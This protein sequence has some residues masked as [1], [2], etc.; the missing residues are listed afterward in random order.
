MRRSVVLA[1][2]AV[3]GFLAAGCK[4]APCH[5]PCAPKPVWVPERVQMTTCYEVVPARTRPQ[6]AA[7]LGLCRDLTPVQV[8]LPVREKVE[9]EDVATAIVPVYRAACVPKIGYVEVQDYRD[10][11]CPKYQCQAVPQCGRVKVVTVGVGCGPCGPRFIADVCE[12]CRT[13]LRFQPV[14]VGEQLVTVP[15]GT[16][17][18]ETQVDSRCVPI[19]V[20]ARTVTCV[21]G[22]H[23]EDQVVGHRVE[24]T[25]VDRG[26]RVV[27]RGMRV[28]P[29]ETLPWRYQVVE[30]PVVVPGYW[31]YL[32]DEAPAV[33]EPGVVTITRGEYE[34]CLR[35][36]ARS[37]R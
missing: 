10:K 30:R 31:A 4:S 26:V 29:K 34:E 18:E 5:D 12:E 13:Y 33:S 27:E 6:H 2:A 36:A 17:L 28:V 37:P 20:G 7:D 22:S 16:H 35:D 9:V 25:H 1:G 32:V 24:T 8:C 19:H 21:T 11:L 23:L 3:L 15:S 14:Q